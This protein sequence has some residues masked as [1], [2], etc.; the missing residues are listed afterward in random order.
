MGALINMGLVSGTHL[1]MLFFIPQ[2]L[3]R[4]LDFTPLQTGIAIV[5]MTATIFIV[6]RWVP[7]WAARFG[8]R[9]LLLLGG[10]FLIVSFVLWVPLNESSSYVRVLIPLL[11]HALGV[12]LI[13]TS[14]TLVAMDRV[15]DSDAGLGSGMLQ[16][17]QQLGGSLGIA[18]V[19]SAYATGAV[20]DQFVPGLRSALLT[21][22]ALAVLATLVAAVTI[23]GRRRGEP[24][25]SATLRGTDRFTS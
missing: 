19:V 4:V 2:Y 6:T 1:A 9:A 15:P 8:P 14:G 13:F 11:V 17:A 24:A 12:A 21:A 23:G 10:I 5:P 16:M 20:D 25:H 7:G 22:G 18:I 3:Q